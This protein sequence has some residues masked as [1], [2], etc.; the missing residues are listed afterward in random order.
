[1][2]SPSTKPVTSSVKVKVTENAPVTGSEAPLEIVTSGLVTSFCTTMALL[3]VPVG[4]VL[5]KALPALSV[6]VTPLAKDSSTVA[7]RLAMSPPARE[8]S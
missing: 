7:F 3:F 2:I 4:V 8:I 1:M 6:M 5:T